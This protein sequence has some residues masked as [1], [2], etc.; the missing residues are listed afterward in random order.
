MPKTSV[1][2]RLKWIH[3]Q[4]YNPLG[5]KFKIYSVWFF[6][7]LLLLKGFE[8]DENWVIALDYVCDSDFTSGTF[9]G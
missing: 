7:G 6:L 5:A 2:D 8:T 3:S 9:A 1:D 4:K